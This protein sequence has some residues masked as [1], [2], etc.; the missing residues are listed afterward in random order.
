MIIIRHIDNNHAN[1]NSVMYG[2]LTII[3]PTMISDKQKLE[4]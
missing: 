2:D 3:P 1:N 4:F